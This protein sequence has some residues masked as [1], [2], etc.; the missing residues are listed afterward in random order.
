MS[1]IQTPINEPPTEDTHKNVI[2][3]ENNNDDEQ[4]ASDSEAI[5]ED[6]KELNLEKKKIEQQENDQNV[7]NVENIENNNNNEN[8][9]SVSVTC[10]PTVIEDFIR[11]FLI[12]NEMHE[13]LD[14]FQR[15]FYNKLQKNDEITTI[16]K[17][18]DIYIQKQELES[19]VKYLQLNLDRMESI[20]EKV[21]K[22]MG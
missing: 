19:K 13:S 1:E 5:L 9:I 12:S 17:I 11:S 6:M 16:C 21:K 4:H 18:P 8:D 2:N 7:E 20:T 10:K 14:V 22:Y 3:T 15:E